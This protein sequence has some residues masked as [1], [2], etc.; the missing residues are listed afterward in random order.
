MYVGNDARGWRVNCENEIREVVVFK[1]KW[2][3]KPDKTVKTQVLQWSR[4]SASGA[5]GEEVTNFALEYFY[6]EATLELEF[7]VL[8]GHS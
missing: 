1:W 6:F 8:R 5:P 3:R 7:K 2:E 4:L